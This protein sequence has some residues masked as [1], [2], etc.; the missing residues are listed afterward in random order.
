MQMNCSPIPAPSSTLADLAAAPYFTKRVADIV[1]GLA[2]ASHEDEALGVL[3]CATRA[4]G[5][6]ASAFVSFIRDDATHESFRFLL[7]CDPIWCC[8]YERTASYMADPWL[9][10][11]LDNSEP[12]R[13]HEIKSQTAQEREVLAL[14]EKYG[15][16]SA[17]I[18]PAPSSGKLTRVGVLCLGSATPGYFDD[19][20]YPTLKLVARS[21]AM[22]LHAWWI[23]RIRRE[24]IQ[25]AQL[26]DEDLVL[27]AHEW[28]GL[29]TKAMA[30][31]LNKSEQSINSRFQR[32]NARLG[33]PNRKAAA[34][35]AAE[36]GLV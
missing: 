16:R 17:L 32:M 20:G 6:D 7:A 27:L 36:Y 12:A 13:G 1:C 24:V 15:F 2:D 35:M 23:Q 31:V 30:T 14:A 10:H 9:Q 3:D 33:V 21:L 5:L 22:E 28:R 26:T 18:V 4:M 25:D 29:A 8:E 11:A 19:E 34:Q